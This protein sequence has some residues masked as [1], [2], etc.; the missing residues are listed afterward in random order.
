M[1]CCLFQSISSLAKAAYQVGVDKN[2][3][4]VNGQLETSD[5]SPY[6][7]VIADELAKVTDRLVLL[8]L[9]IFVCRLLIGGGFRSD[10]TNSKLRISAY[11]AL[12]DLI[13]NSPAD[14]Y[15]VVQKTTMVVLQK[16]E[17]LLAVEDSLVAPA[18]RSQLR[19]LQSSLCATLESVLHKIRPEDAPNASDAIMSGLLRIMRGLG[20]DGGTVMEEAML[21]V[22][23]LIDCELCWLV[24]VSMISIIFSSFQWSAPHSRS[25]WR[26][27]SRTCCM[28]WTLTKIPSSVSRQ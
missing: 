5:L 8:S 7:Q 26:G 27:S 12:M 14:C 24:V 6:S 1:S 23:S 17:A 20:V 10:G 9:S 18:D 2:G 3:T 25:T 15:A 22:S 13:R 19:D 28:P 11:E 16:M 21:A 4:N